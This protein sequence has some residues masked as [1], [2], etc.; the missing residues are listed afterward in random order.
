MA[1]LLDANVL[2][3]GAKD[4]YAFD[5]CPGFWEFL[6]A[7][8]D[9]GEVFS[10]QK[11]LEE[12]QGKDDSLRKWANDLGERFFLPDDPRSLVAR[13]EVA[14][15]LEARDYTKAAI[16]KFMGD[17]DPLLI[18][19]AKAHG[20]VIVTHEG[21]F[22]SAQRIR[23]PPVCDALGVKYSKTWPMLRDLGAQ[24]VLPKPENR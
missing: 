4:H 3:Q 10:I 16:R 14:L 2:M 21:L 18:A 20:H 24:F 13:S 6:A 19:C 5:I 15:C 22:D 12:C 9:R 17:A 1:Y 7:A 11:V 23:I 8:N